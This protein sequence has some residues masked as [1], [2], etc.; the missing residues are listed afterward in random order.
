MCTYPPCLL[1]KKLT[2]E[3]QDDFYEFNINNDFMRDIQVKKN[4]KESQ[5]NTN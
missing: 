5:K 3:A 2:F 1:I 4:I